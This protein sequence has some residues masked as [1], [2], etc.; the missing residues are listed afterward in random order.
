[1]RLSNYC[2]GE[3]STADAEVLIRLAR[4]ST[5]VLEYGS[6]GSTL[7]WSQFCPPGTMIYS[8][9]SKEEWRDRTSDMLYRCSSSQPKHVKFFDFAKAL[10]PAEVGDYSWFDLIFL[11][12]EG[13]NRSPKNRIEIAQ[14]VWPLLMPGGV[15]AMHDAIWPIGGDFVRWA[16]YRHNEI[17]SLEFESA[18]VMLTKCVERPV[19]GDIDAYEQAKPW[20][21]GHEPLPAGWPKKRLAR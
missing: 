14:K 6:G 16:S 2:V 13:E 10:V 1:M 4:K 19:G 17:K 7:I 18:V 5:R 15:M 21:R 12:C 9:E 3:L 8:G 11:D 20:E